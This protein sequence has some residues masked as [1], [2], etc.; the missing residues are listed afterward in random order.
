MIAKQL[1]TDGILPLKTSDTGRTALSWMEDFRVMHLPIVNNEGFLGL[2]S[3]MDIYSFNDF[4]EAL[5][6]HSL[7]LVKPFVNEYQHIY[8]VLRIMQQNH[9]TLIPVVDEHEKYLG[10][11]TLQSLLEHFAESL[12]VTEPGGVIVLEMSLNDFV[13]SEIARIVESNDTKILSFFIH[14]DKDSTKIEVT[15][16]LNRKEIAPIIQTFTRFNYNI[17]ASF[18]EN[19]DVEDLRDRFDS[20]MNYLNI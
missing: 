13:L 9:L 20:L 8:D 12:S 3:E 18:S 15:L 1:M 2:V 5:G 10:S 16:K 14:S 4:D 7:S 6:N 17:V 11:V 19:D